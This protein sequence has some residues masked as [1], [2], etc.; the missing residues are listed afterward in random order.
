MSPSVTSSLVIMPLS[1]EMA[2]ISC[3]V[4]TYS[5]LAFA[6]SSESSA[7]SF[8]A[9]CASDSACLPAASSR[10]AVA[11]SPAASA[12]AFASS[13]FLMFTAAALRFAL[14]FSRRLSPKE[15]SAAARLCSRAAFCSFSSSDA[16]FFC[17]AR[18]L[19]RDSLR[20]WRHA[21]AI[22]PLVP[23]LYF[24]SWSFARI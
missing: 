24:S 9:R 14:A 12:F 1:F 21:A 2:V 13:T 15:R 5:T 17:R 8:S 18:S 16:I 4:R 11:A 10:C 22:L 6:T 3:S 19:A 20:P 7:C 23:G